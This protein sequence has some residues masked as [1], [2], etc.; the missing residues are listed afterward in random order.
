MEAAVHLEDGEHVACLGV[1]VCLGAVKAAAVDHHVT[2]SNLA[3]GVQPFEVA[4]VCLRRDLAGE[5]RGVVRNGANDDHARL[6]AR[7]AA[8]ALHRRQQLVE[9]G[10][11][12]QV[13][14]AD[15]LLKAVLRD[16]RLGAHAVRRECS[17]ARHVEADTELCRVLEHR[18][19][20]GRIAEHTVEAGRATDRAGELAAQLLHRCEAAQV[21]LFNGVGSLG[22]FKRLRHTLH[23]GAVAHTADNVPIASLGQHLGGVEAEAGRGAGDDGGL[24]LAIRQSATGVDAGDH[25]GASG[26][27]HRTRCHPVLGLHRNALLPV[28]LADGVHARAARHARRRRGAYASGTAGSGRRHGGAARGTR[29]AVQSESHGVVRR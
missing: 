10:E 13:D 23:L 15:R 4:E 9:H 2:V 1:L 18:V 7:L 3:A 21:D 6:R 29:D 22:E 16:E 12:R 8:M 27:L 5:L 14:H 17:G 24:L 28:G 20:D 19:V 26:V 25:L 11:V